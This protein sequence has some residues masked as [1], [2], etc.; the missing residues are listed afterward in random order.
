MRID[1]VRREAVAVAPSVRQTARAVAFANERAGWIASQLATLPEAHPFENGAVIP[2]R[3]VDTVLER[4]PGRA[5]P[6]FEYQPYR[7]LIIGAPDA[8][9]F[10]ARVKRFLVNEAKGDFVARARTHAETLGVTPR[11]IT[12]KDTKSR[13]GSCTVDGSLSFSWRLIFAPSYVLDYLAAHEVA[14][15]K[16]LNHSSRFWAAVRKCDPDHAKG[17]AWLRE[18]GQLLHAYGAEA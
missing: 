4:A 17:R 18:H 16:E 15:L 12:V 10:A 3:G 9:T 13:W 5:A 2:I 8:E 6:R 14:H 1:P 7:R 11:K